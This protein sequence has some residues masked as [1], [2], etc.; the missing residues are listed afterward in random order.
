[1]N[2]TV[3]A[4]TDV[5]QNRDHNED[6][7]LVADLT[8][9]DLSLGDAGRSFTLGPKGCLLLVADGMGGAQGG[10]VASQ[11]AVDIIFEKLSSTWAND[12]DNSLDMFGSRVR[13]A[14]ETANRQIHERSN[15]SADLQG[16]G[17]TATVVGI[18]DGSIL[19]GQVGDSRAY[20]IRNGTAVQITR[21]QS[22]VQRLVDTGQITEEEA[23]RLPTKNLILQ[24]LGPSPTLEVVETR[25]PI[26]RGDAALVCSDGLSG[27]VEAD[28]LAAVVTEEDD[29]STACQ[30]LVDLSN[31]RGGPDNI[32]VVIARATG[33]GL[34]PPEEVGSRD[35]PEVVG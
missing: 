1:V 34:A 28:E 22:F 8:T 27:L 19:A 21:D 24:A 12:S 23:N 15:R 9:G 33:N 29:L 2:I 32:T 11:M 17:S 7:F 3:S 31:E 35:D 13:E 26:Q 10:E 16:M 5:G 4:R 18:L 25:H 30:R 20:L 14:V 6:R